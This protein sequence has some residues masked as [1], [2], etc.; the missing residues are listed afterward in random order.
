ME[1][2]CK[3][4][5][6]APVGIDAMLI[7]IEVSMTTGIGIYLVGLPDSAV[8]ESL[9]RITAVL[10]G[11]GYKVPGRRIIINLAPANIRKEGS[12]Y[13]IAIAIAILSISG[14][15]NVKMRSD[16]LVLGE[17]SLDGSL[18]SV[19]GILPILIRAE[20]LGFKACIIPRD[21]EAEGCEIKNVVIFCASSLKDVIEILS[22]P[23]QAYPFLLDRAAPKMKRQG[24]VYQDFCEVKGQEFAKRGMEIAASGGHN[25]ILVGSPGSGK[26]MLAKALPSILPSMEREESLE[27]S[28]IYSVAGGISEFDGLIRERPFRSPHHSCSPVS[29]IGGGQG[30]LPG[31]ISLA[32]NGVLY[33]D[34]IAEYSRYILDLLRQ[35]M[36]D[37]TVSISRAKYKI[38]YPASFMLVA[39]MNP[40][41]CGYWGERDSQCNCS[42]GAISR[43]TSKVSGPLMDRIDIQIR[44]GKMSGDKLLKE[45]KEEKS[46]VIAERVERAREIQR[47]RFR[48]TDIYTNAQM[49]S[50]MMADYCRVGGKER[51]FLNEIIEKFSLSGRA[52]SR[53]LKLSRTIAD[54]SG[55]ENIALEDIC[56]AVQFRV[57]VDTI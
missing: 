54:L 41:P 4:Y 57:K 25:I 22:D 20:S 16:F 45:G 37:R 29:L 24:E 5:S 31:E 11:M 49:N 26:S 38:K 23:E 55:R 33:L 42:E 2:I 27:T 50:S 39:S 8:K 3:V 40:C 1:S 56:E 34:E 44:V 36:E 47:I 6:A 7:T 43:Y 48:D 46:A 52:Y 53:I 28:M 21:A 18:R 51:A 15:I 17:L 13:D 12:S 9:M 32:H 10:L 30:A 14:Q 19:P 35:P